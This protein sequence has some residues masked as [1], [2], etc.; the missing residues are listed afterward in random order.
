MKIIKNTCFGG[1]GLSIKAKIAVAK[2]KGKDIYFFS[3]NKEPLT[4]KEALE[5]KQTL[6]FDYTVPDP[7]ERGID[8]RGKNGLYTEANKIS[9]EISM[10]FDDRTDKDIIAIVEKLGKEAGGRSANLVVCEIPDDIEY[11]I[12]EYDGMEHIAEAH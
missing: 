1:Y 3:M 6:V 7:Y 2:K 9:K 5:G 10:D 4:H 8:K 11:E 12:C